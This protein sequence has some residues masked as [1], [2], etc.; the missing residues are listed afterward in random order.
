[1]RQRQLTRLVS[2]VERIL[3]A[4]HGDLSLSPLDEASTAARGLRR[5]LAID[6]LPLLAERDS[7]PAFAEQVLKLLADW[8]EQVA[9][10]LPEARGRNGDDNLL[11]FCVHSPGPL[12]RYAFRLNDGRQVAF[13]A[14]GGWDPR[15][16]AAGKRQRFVLAA[17]EPPM[18]SADEL[19]VRFASGRTSDAK[20][21]LHRQVLTAIESDPH[22]DAWLAALTA[23]HPAARPARRSVLTFHLARFAGWHERDVLI[24]RNLQAQLQ[25][26]LRQFLGTYLAGF[27]GEVNARSAPVITDVATTAQVLGHS[28]IDPLSCANTALEGL[29]QQVP[30]VEADDYCVAVGLADDGLLQAAARNDRQHAAWREL[31]GVERPVGE[32]DVDWLRRHPALPIDTSFFEPPVCARIA[33]LVSS[34]TLELDGLLIHADNAAALRWLAG[35]WPQ[36]VKVIFIDP[37]Y[38]TGSGVWSYADRQ[39]H[40][41]WL[42]AI[43]DRLTLAR[44]RL[45]DDGTIFVSLDDHEQARLRLLMDDVFGEENFLATIIWEK[46]H[47]RKNSARHFSVSHDYILGFARDKRRWRRQLLPRSSTAEYANPDGDPRGPWKPDPIY[48]NKPYSAQ[49]RLK[50]PN[51]VMLD[52]PPGR[53]WRFSEANLLAKAARE[54]VLWGDGS[55]Y[56]LVKRYLGD[57]QAGLVPVTLFSRKFA[58][59]NALAASEL[60]ALF[61]QLPSVSYPKPTRLIERI[62]QIA[63]EPGGR[64]TVLDFY[65]GSGTTADAVL[66]LNR[67]D[68][69]RRRYVLIEQGPCFENVL[70]PRVLKAAYSDRWRA[71]RPIGSGAVQQCLRIVR[72]ESFESALCR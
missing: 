42:A 72:L 58:G 55:S 16:L 60:R 13:V 30:R 23:P 19:H 3:A 5:F 31:L 64:D 66:R 26:G 2:A 32:I 47:T 43:L 24:F 41:V 6:L 70:K 44:E 46:V 29:W 50:K 27:I 9:A 7:N 21:A 38:N 11:E 49:Y 40:D 36:P 65:A 34:G 33:D 25:N 61:G 45:D 4:C 53:Y 14:P 59:D 69:G 1:M 51:G 18:V 56:P 17:D 67:A 68:G 12:A 71:G 10:A 62:L 48:A 52:P 57:V 28:L 39:A 15:R 54:E 37:P 63:S 35:A 22:G 8:L 20:I